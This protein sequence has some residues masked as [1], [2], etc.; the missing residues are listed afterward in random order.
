MIIIHSFPKEKPMET[1]SKTTQSNKTQTCIW[2]LK[3]GP[4][5]GENCGREVSDGSYCDLCHSK[6]DLIK[7]VSN[8][9][10]ECKNVK[11]PYNDQVYRRPA[12]FNDYCL[13]CLSN[14]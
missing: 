4:H 14:E 9:S 13:L 8:S 7:K 3:Y 2:K 6:M 12:V 11:D 10:G 1:Q 5:A